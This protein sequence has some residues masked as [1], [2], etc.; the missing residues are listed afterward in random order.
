MFLLGKQRIGEDLIHFI[1]IGGIGMSGIALIMHNLG[2]KVQ[3]SDVGKNYNT[4]KLESLGIRVFEG[5]HPENITGASY[6]VTSSAITKDNKEVTSALE[7][8]IPIISRSQMLAELMRLKFSIAVSGSHGKTTTTSLVACVFEAAGLAPTVINGGIINNKL[9]NAYIGSGDYLIAEADESDATFINIP[10]TV[11][12]ITNIDPEHLD[13][14]HNF[15]NVINAF[16]SFITN[17]PFYGFAVA[18]VDNKV[19]EDLVS[20]ITD[21]KIITYGIENKDAH[22]VAYNIDSDIDASTF[23]IKFHSPYLKG[24]TII[25]NITIP[26]PGKHNVLNCLAA[27]AIAIELDFGIRVIKQGFSNFQGVKRRFTK[28]FEYNGA[29]IIDDYAHHPVEIVATLS[30]ARLIADKRQGRVIAI[31]QPHRYTRVQAL[32][33]EFTECFD[34][35]DYL[36]ITDIYSAGENP[37]QNISALAL[38]DKIREQRIHNNAQFIDSDEKKIAETVK[39]IAKKGDIIVMMGAGTISSWANNLQN[40]IN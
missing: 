26:T 13:F 25:E 35:A 17:L 30:T 10:A 2:Y 12:V 23:D 24:A 9:S 31:L 22:L 40:I 29:D 39:A 15:D 5:H 16:K 14:Y 7:Q 38:V 21:R 18:C 11:A 4:E 27:I 37:I 28:V 36:Y 8:K 20:N 34:N 1:G 33:K 3:G 19:V 6:V 32:F